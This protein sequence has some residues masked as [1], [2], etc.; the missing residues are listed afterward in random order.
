MTKLEKNGFSKKISETLLELSKRVNSKEMQFDCFLQNT[1]KTVL[2]TLEAD[3]IGFWHYDE[4][5][6]TLSC[7]VSIQANP[8]LPTAL[9]TELRVDNYPHYFQEL[10]KQRVVSVDDTWSDDCMKDFHTKGYLDEHNVGATLDTQVYF[11]DKLLAVVCVEEVGRKRNWHHLEQ[12]FLGSVGELVGLAYS[13]S[14]A[15]QLREQLKSSEEQYRYLFEH[16]PS[17]LLIYD[18][19]TLRLLEVNRACI[20]MLGT[21]REELLGS[22]LSEHISPTDINAFKDAVERIGKQYKMR[23]G[24]WQLLSK[25]KGVL[26]VEAHSH[27][28]SFL[29][30]SRRAVL[31]HD[32]TQQETAKQK[33]R[34]NINILSNMRRAISNSFLMLMTDTQG[35]ILETNDSFCQYFGYGLKEL[36]GKKAQDLTRLESYPRSFWEK[37]KTDLERDNFWEGELCFTSNEREC[38]WLVVYLNA[39][40]NEQGDLEHIL[41]LMY[42]IDERKKMELERD[43]L[44]DTLITRNQRLRTFTHL[45]SHHIRLPISR[46]LGLV[47]LMDCEKVFTG[48]Q[49]QIWTYI[50][51][52]VE[53]L[54]S[55]VTDLNGVLEVR[56]DENF[57]EVDLSEMLITTRHLLSTPMRKIKPQ[58][59]LKLKQLRVVSIPS[60]IENIFFQLL[61]NTLKFRHPKRALKLSISSYKEENERWALCFKDNGMGIDMARH[62]DD[63]FNMYQR[64]HPWV[65][66]KG[67]GL[68]TIKRQV[69]MLGGRIQLDSKLNEGTSIYLSFPIEKDKAV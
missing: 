67:L 49:E 9:N 11:R 61:D 19:T 42:P 48:E 47:D 60:F 40:L 51:Q 52:S 55:I 2:A 35:C 39:I 1:L 25:K 10:N 38:L 36:Y 64:F 5:Q 56:A 50:Q 28:I 54:D 45:T 7:K 57:A 65:P 53:E 17:P 6:V 66:G 46:L 33:L 12:H 18:T 32:I 4:A 68:F 62:E 16:S 26:I 31:L 15:E 27:A 30:K 43:E 58:I 69:E 41:A 24:P 8:S 23:T 37:I 3:R 21:E 14:E 34:D 13:L 59:E 44:I 29:G 20:E 22:S 63:L